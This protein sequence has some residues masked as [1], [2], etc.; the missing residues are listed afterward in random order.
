VRAPGI[1]EQK[2]SS[3]ATA[4]T[5]ATLPLSIFFPM[6]FCV[7]EQRGA[8]HP[9][10]DISSSDPFLRIISMRLSV[11]SFASCVRFRCKK[12]HSF[13]KHEI[14]IS[15]V[16]KYDNTIRILAGYMSLK[17]ISGVLER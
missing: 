15:W 3:R 13:I 5:I 4:A 6:L 2:P 7:R 16:P 11:S 1:H 14:F 12:G 8:L 10:Q 17:V 9:P